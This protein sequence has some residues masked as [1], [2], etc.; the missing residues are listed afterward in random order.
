MKKQPK[1][2]IP[3]YLRYVLQM[4]STPGVVD[5]DFQFHTNKRLNTIQFKAYFTM[6]NNQQMI[7]LEAG[8]RGY[9]DNLN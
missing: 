1:V 3:Q 9:N 6:H 7:A 2:Q 4:L 8:L 5:T